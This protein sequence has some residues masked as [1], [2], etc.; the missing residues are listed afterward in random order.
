MA[1]EGLF[2]SLM[3]MLRTIPGS[4]TTLSLVSKP[5]REQI[6][7]PTFEQTTML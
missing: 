4:L 6:D 2:I 1:G 7:F 5:I 3:A